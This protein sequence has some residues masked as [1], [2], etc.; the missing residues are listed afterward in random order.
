MRTTSSLPSGSLGRP[1]LIREPYQVPTY[2]NVSS[3]ETGS[4]LASTGLKL[5]AGRK[6]RSNGSEPP[7]RESGGP[8]TTRSRAQ[9]I[10]DVRGVSPFSQNQ[11]S[12]GAQGRFT[13]WSSGSGAPFSTK[14]STCGRRRRP[15]RLGR[16]SGATSPCLASD[17]RRRAWRIRTPTRTTSPLYGD[18]IP[19]S[20]HRPVIYLVDPVSPSEQA[21]PPQN[22]SNCRSP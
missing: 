1:V 14:R 9:G 8:R 10:R 13:S 11:V 7:K 2:A 12:P 17:G 21:S 4:A 16:V 18:R 19:R 3:R 6:N 22:F 20:A 15:P 5:R